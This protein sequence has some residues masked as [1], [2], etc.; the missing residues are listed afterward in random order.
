M[1]TVTLSDFLSTAQL[2]TDLMDSLGRGGLVCLPCN[3]SYRILVDFRNEDAVLRLFQSKRR[4]KK[5]PS[6]V[7]I[8]SHKMLDQV[9]DR[10]EPMGKRLAETIWP[11]P[12]TLLVPTHSEMPRRLAR[13]IGGIHGNKVGVRIPD[14]KWLKEFIEAIGHPVIVSSANREKKRGET[15]PAQIRQ[16]FGR[17]LD[18]F[19]DDGEL[20]QEMAST[21]VDVTQ[22]ELRVVR[23]GSLSEDFLKEC[24]VSYN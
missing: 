1:K 13:Q 23:A 9:T 11:G 20:R 17:E 22:G 7:F 15:S 8:S 16:N 14:S 24:M 18:F 21:V 12:L 4:V 5:A 10:L 19:V 3:G 6:L 2:K